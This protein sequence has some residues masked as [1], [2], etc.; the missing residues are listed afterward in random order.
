MQLPTRRSD[1]SAARDGVLVY[2]A[3]TGRIAVSSGGAFLQIPQIVDA[4]ASASASG[5][6]GQIAFDA[7]YFYVCTAT[8]TWRRIAHSTW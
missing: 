3:A 6:A 7:S 1:F 5:S 2:D 8:D 4:P